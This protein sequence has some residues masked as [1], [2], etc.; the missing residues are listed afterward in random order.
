[1]SASF[2]S[3]WISMSSSSAGLVMN[4]LVSLMRRPFC[5][6]VSRAALARPSLSRRSDSCASSSSS[7][8]ASAPFSFS[9]NCSF[10][11]TCVRICTV[12]VVF[13]RSLSSSSL[14]SSIFSFRLWFSILSCSKSMRCRPSASSS[15]C[16]SV[17]S[18]RF[19][20]LDKWMFF[21]RTRCTSSSFS[22]SS[23]SSCASSL[24]LMG[25]PVLE[26]SAL[27]ATSS[28]KCLYALA[29]SSARLMRSSSVLF[30]PKMVLW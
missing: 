26:C 30:M 29:M 20:W 18:M 14:R 16:L 7:W 15:F 6:S 12:V 1:M 2:F 25:R 19:S 4:T 28:L 23:C 21:K 5:R 17:C 3:L 22:W 13:L 8:P 11:R 10:S 27:L 9:T 24:S